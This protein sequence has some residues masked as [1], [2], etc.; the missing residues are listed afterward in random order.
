MSKYLTAPVKSSSLPKGI[1][2]IIG[3]EA[4]ER[5]SFYGMRSI[6]FV[7][8]TTYLMQPGGLL[9]TFTDQE[10]KSWTHLFV[11]SA[12][13]FP[14]MGALLSDAWWGKYRTIITLS[15]AY[16]AGHACLAF[17]ETFGDTRAWLFTGLVL[18]AIGSGGIKPCVSAH[19]GDQFGQSNGHLLSKV[20]G[21]FYFSI[22]FGAFVS[23]LLTPWLLEARA[24]EY[25]HPFIETL[26]GEKAQG[27]ILFGP[28]WAFGLPGVLMA[29]ATLV[30]WMGRHK[31]IHIQPPAKASVYFK[32][33][34][35][36]EGM[37]AIGRISIIFA[38]IILFWCLFDQIG[39]TWLLQAKQLDRIL[40][41]WIPLVGGKEMLAAQVASVFNPLFILLLIPVFNYWIY[42][43]LDKIFPLTPLRK[44]GLGLFGSSLAFAMVAIIQ[45][46]VDAGG[47]PHVGWQ[48]LACL[49]LTGAEVM[50]SITGLEFAYTQAPR[51]MKSFILALFLFTVSLGNFLTAMVTK[52]LTDSQGQ[53]KL[54]LA[55]ELWFWSVFILIGAIA[56][57]PVAMRYKAKEYLQE[58]KA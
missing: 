5:F 28:H 36:K 34:F 24:G 6:L 55:H 8:M 20:F 42:P 51:H 9:D 35:S 33:T 3:N 54:S 22:N 10:A 7:Y 56:Y 14:L 12:Y 57:V 45:M 58:E 46:A 43:A 49:L 17:M 53:A 37:Q 18:I 40:P 4:A 50:V 27:E 44:I 25:V 48:I 52:I 32:Q 47:E 41:E 30:F 2:Y 39:T 21:W 1:P 11:A 23:G 26:V 13:F 19:V 38:F 29:L 16:C 31:F 15:L